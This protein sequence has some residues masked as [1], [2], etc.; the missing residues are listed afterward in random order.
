MTA[1]SH[2]QPASVPQSHWI[3]AHRAS[4]IA[5][6]EAQGYKPDTVATYARITER[7]CVEV[8]RRNLA[9]P[10]LSAEDVESIR[11]AVLDG[12]SERSRPGSIYP[13]KRFV[14]HLIHAGVAAA[15]A[16]EK[17]PTPMNR[18]AR[19]YEHY[20]RH[21]RG[22]SE[23]TIYHC[24]RFLVRFMTFRFGDELGDLEAIT[25]DDIVD[26]LLMFRGGPAASRDK[27]PPTHL[28]NLFKFLFWSGKTK[29]DLAA[30]IPRIAAPKLPPRPRYLSPED[31]ERLIEEV[32]SNDPV[33]RRNYAM[34]LLIARLG[35]RAPELVAIQLEDI[36]WRAGEIL[37][38][39]KGQ[40]HDR[41]PLPM[42]V[43]EAIVD[44]IRNG[45][46]GTSRSL[47]VCSKA[48]HRPF[49]NAQIINNL[50]RRAF[51]LTGLRPPQAYVGSH[52]LRHSLATDLLQKGASLDEVG[53]ML[54]HRSRMATTIYAQYDVEALRSIA[55]PWPEPVSPAPLEQG[56][57]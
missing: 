44:Y 32:R 10:G 14:D 27:T 22:L 21:Q 49:V 17:T 1:K 30:C 41:M 34:M 18:L 24:I 47:F 48:P 8:R 6:L 53:D 39:G 31:V 11:T 57:V 25:P 50:L 40:L 42:D 54:R 9:D 15:P 46:A 3:D 29:R 16:E 33:G 35:L 23:A 5:Q 38:R 19:E 20:L 26:Y 56:G 12:N 55:R 4:F 28:R 36:D 45:R 7:F 2:A 52:V 43:G 37:I 13:L 51:K